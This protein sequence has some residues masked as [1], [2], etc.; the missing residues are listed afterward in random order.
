MSQ[1]RQNDRPQDLVA[2]A[3][4]RLWQRSRAEAGS[5]AKWARERLT[6][7]QLRADRDRMYQKLGKEARHLHEAGELEHPGVARG[8]ARI[9]ERVKKITDLEDQLRAVGL[10]PEPDP[11]PASP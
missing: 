10:E 5:A 4:S 8:V 1:D 6:L 9:R 7:R 2:D 3:L 11:E